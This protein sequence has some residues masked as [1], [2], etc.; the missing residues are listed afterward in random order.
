[1]SKM[2]KRLAFADAGA[3]QAHAIAV[4]VDLLQFDLLPAQRRAQL[5][6]RCQAR[7]RVPRK[8]RH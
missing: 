8:R 5:G 7:H 6:Q 1:M 4:K 3:Q 2:V